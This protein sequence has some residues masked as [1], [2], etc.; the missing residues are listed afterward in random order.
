VS[1]AVVAWFAL[2]VPGLRE[3]WSEPDDVP[4]APLPDTGP[5]V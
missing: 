3:P 4:V 2:N 5:T 1:A